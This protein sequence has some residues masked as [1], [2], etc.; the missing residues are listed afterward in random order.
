VMSAVR[1]GVAVEGGR[2]GAADGGALSADE[3]Q[4]RVEE[5]VASFLNECK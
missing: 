3:H 5:V 4:R 2:D 1:S